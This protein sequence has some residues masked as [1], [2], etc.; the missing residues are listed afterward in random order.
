MEVSD[1]GY[2][3]VI[4]DND[5]E[6]GWASYTFSNGEMGIKPGD[7]LVLDND[8]GLLK[9]GDR[10]KINDKHIITKVKV[11]HYWVGKLVTSDWQDFDDNFSNVLKRIEQ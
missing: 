5:K 9:A 6:S 4:N 8:L 10:I 1:F 7:T 2:V 3:K 11:H